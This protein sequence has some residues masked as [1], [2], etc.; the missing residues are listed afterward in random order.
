MKT[1]STSGSRTEATY[2]TPN[3][4]TS[5]GYYDYIAVGAFPKTSQV[6]QRVAK[7][8][9]SGNPTS[10]VY[11]YQYET[12][13]RPLKSGYDYRADGQSRLSRIMPQTSIKKS[14]I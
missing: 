5:W 9:T 3:G 14:E 2:T 10:E 8:D 4:S 7:L 12:S 6:F 11:D 13:G 1:N